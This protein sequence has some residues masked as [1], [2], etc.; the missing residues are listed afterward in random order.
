MSILVLGGCGYIG[1]HTIVELYKAGHEVVVVDN[2]S[3]SYKSV[4]A[5]LE[6]IV[7]RKIA[8]EE[9]DATDFVAMEAV[10]QKY[11]TISAVIHFAAFKSIGESVKNP[12]KYYKN[13]IQSLLVVAELMQK[14]NVK[15]I[16]FSSSASVYG[17][18]NGVAIKEDS[19]ISKATNPYG[20]TKIMSEQILKDWAEAERNLN[21]IILRYFNPIGAH[22]SGFIGEESKDI[23]NNLLPYVAKVAFG[24]LDELHVFGD[25]YDTKDGTGVRDYIH[26][27]DL[28]RGHVM[29]IPHFQKSIGGVKTYNLGTGKGYSVLEVIR[30]FERVSE[31]EIKYEVVERRVGDVAINYADPSKAR[32]ELGWRA[33]FEIHEMCKD[34]WRWQMRKSQ[35]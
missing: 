34:A 23:P 15:N 1:S 22:P 27:V 21:C 29:A 8:L 5:G 25:D 13:N 14:Y 16:I 17:D 31:R 9:I 20:W 24:E 32:E 11:E 33:E 26:V 35:K 7:Q 18:A 4:I 10:F 19:I 2:F 6:K 28:A 30:E 12:L 3:N